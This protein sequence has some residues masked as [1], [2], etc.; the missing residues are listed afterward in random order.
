MIE[1]SCTKCRKNY[2]VSDNYAGKRVRCKECSSVNQIPAAEPKQ[3]SG[4]S[5][6]AFNMLL[7]ELSQYEKTAPE[8]DPSA[9]GMPS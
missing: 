8:M 6:A 2:R 7:E 1:F 9:T 4:D 5:V 3:S